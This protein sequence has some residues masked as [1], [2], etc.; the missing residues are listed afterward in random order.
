M[1]RRDCP[2]RV[3]AIV[4][5]TAAITASSAGVDYSAAGAVDVVPGRKPAMTARW[6]PARNTQYHLTDSPC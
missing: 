3:E 6:I 5:L 4:D 1:A 2:E